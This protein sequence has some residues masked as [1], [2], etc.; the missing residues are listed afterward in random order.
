MIMNIYIW[1]WIDTMVFLTINL[2]MI[3][4]VLDSIGAYY[5][6]KPYIIYTIL[7]TQLRL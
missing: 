6:L 4:Q 1:K 3:N 2:L 7:K 5:N